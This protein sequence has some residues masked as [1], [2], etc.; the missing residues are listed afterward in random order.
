M[1]DVRHLVLACGGL[2]LSALSWQELGSDTWEDTT[3]RDGN[4]TEEL[5]EF[6]VVSDG[7]LQVSR[8]DTSLLVV[9]SSVTSQFEDF[10]SQVLQ[11][12][13]EVNGSTRSNSSGVGASLELSVDSTDWELET[14]LG[15]SGGRL[16]LSGGLRRGGRKEGRREGDG[17]SRVLR[18]QRRGGASFATGMRRR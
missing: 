5:V 8:D 13:S 17:Q 6:F 15:R 18:E 12:G 4:T 11:D 3:L 16:G 1:L 9:S 14:S 10:G 2:L 7:E